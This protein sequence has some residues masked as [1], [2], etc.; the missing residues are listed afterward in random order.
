MIGT[1]GDVSLSREVSRDEPKPSAP[2]AVSVMPERFTVTKAD[3]IADQ[4]LPLYPQLSTNLGK[5]CLL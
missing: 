4:Y 2:P 1:E 3:A 5:F